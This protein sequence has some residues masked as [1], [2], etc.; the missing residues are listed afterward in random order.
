VFFLIK[1]TRKPLRFFGLIG[2]TVWRGVRDHPVPGDLPDLDFGGSDRPLLPWES[3]S[4]SWG[5]RASR[6]ACSARSS[7]SRTP[8]A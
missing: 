4:W 1:F 6:S 7:S 5:F 2:S 3:R 8:G